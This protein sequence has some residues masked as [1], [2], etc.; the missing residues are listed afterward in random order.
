MLF[1]PVPVNYLAT[2]T[3]FSVNEDVNWFRGGGA[4]TGLI[5]IKLMIYELITN[6]ECRRKVRT[7]RF[8]WESLTDRSSR[9]WVKEK[10]RNRV[11][12]RNALP[13]SPPRGAFGNPHHFTKSLDPNV[14]YHAALVY[15]SARY[16]RGVDFIV[17]IYEGAGSLTVIPSLSLST[18]LISASNNTPSELQRRLCTPRIFVQRKRIDKKSCSNIRTWK[19]SLDYVESFFAVKVY[20]SRYDWGVTRYGS[21]LEA[22]PDRKSVV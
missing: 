3:I 7:Q 17:N 20:S 18:V 16:Y 14:W 5:E 9:E 21:R 10:T 12:E 13:L 15:F 8:T 1:S 4:Y 11:V 19:Y 2:S 6:D 22:Q